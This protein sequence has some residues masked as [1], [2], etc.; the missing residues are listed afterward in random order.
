MS[1]ASLVVLPRDTAAQTSERAP[2]TFTT[3]GTIVGFGAERRSVEIAHETI[4]GFMGAMTM[5]F[6]TRAAAQ[7][8]GLAL[9]DR[10]SFTFT[11]TP[12]RHFVLD[13]I[14]KD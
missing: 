1:V 10:V 9:R 3:R 2:R 5:P 13:A 12:E 14:R 11:M 6:E 4:P 8:E 7:L